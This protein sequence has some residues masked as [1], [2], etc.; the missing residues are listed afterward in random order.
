ME[1]VRLLDCGRLDSHALND[2]LRPLSHGEKFV[3]RGKGL[4]KNPVTSGLVEELGLFLLVG[5]ELEEQLLLLEVTRRVAG[6]L[7]QWLPLR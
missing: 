1:V 3:L 4:P 7:R 5:K 6:C 2:P